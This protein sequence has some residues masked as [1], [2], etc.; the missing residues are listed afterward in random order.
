MVARTD[1]M[2]SLRRRDGVAVLLLQRP[3]VNALSTDL[4]QALVAMLDRLRDD[5]EVLGVVIAGADRV[6]SAGAD[7]AEFGKPPRS[8]SL[9]ETLACL[10]AYPKCTVAALRGLALGGGLELALA[11][12]YRLAQ[13]EAEF[14]LPET[15]LGLIPGAG[16]TQRLPRLVGVPRAIDM[17]CGAERIGAEQAWDWGM[18]DRVVDGDLISAAV[19]WAL[20]HSPPVAPLPRVSA[21]PLAREPDHDQQ[22]AAHRQTARRRWPSQAAP[23]AAVESVENAVLLPFAAGLS[24]ERKLFLALRDGAQ[25]SALRHVFAAERAS[26]RISRA[27]R[28][29]VGE[30]RR[31]A[32]IGAG[33][34]GAIIAGAFAAAGIP[35]RLLDRDQERLDRGMQLIA[36]GQERAQRRGQLSAAAAA[37]SLR[38]IDTTVSYKDLSDVDLVVEAVFEDMELK[39]AVF[40]EMQRH[41]SSGC[42]FATNTS[43]LDIDAIA[44]DV[45]SP[46]RVVGMHFFNPADRMNLLEVVRC[47]HTSQ[48]TLQSVRWLGK[49]LGKIPVSVGNAFGFAANRSYAAYGHAAQRLLL[50]GATPA[51]VDDAMTA[52]GM[53]MGPLAVQDLSGLDIGYAARRQNPQPPSDPAYFRPSDT[54]VE[55]GMLGC[56]AGAGFYRYDS[57]GGKKTVNED[58]LRL[59]RA[60]ADALGIA[61]QPCDSREIPERMLRALAEEGEKILAAGIIERLDDLDV[62]WV[63]GYGFPRWRGGPMLHASRRLGEKSPASAGQRR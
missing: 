61:R 16:G 19:A 8:P 49:R 60:A 18:V 46:Q 42:I 53:A 50:E 33:A 24:A 31:V 37:R 54:L 43:Y 52:W 21:L 27:E 55:H 28:A 7:I 39:Q 35:V 2:V 41:C 58:A 20:E 6:F 13:P 29:S 5:A 59:I 56:K 62:I 48:Q 38:A 11:C 34:M 15:R 44:A 57:E 17:I 3:P 47:R 1:A 22:F 45:D 30:V 36:R 23:L 63:N 32:V 25:S 51:Q 4:R 26:G 14:G 10:D 40:G 9:P 12:H